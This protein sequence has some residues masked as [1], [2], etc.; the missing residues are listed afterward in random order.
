MWCVYTVEYYSD[1]KQSENNSICS[2]MHDLDIIML[3][4]VSQRKTNTI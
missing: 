1:I 2:N 4:E 3:G